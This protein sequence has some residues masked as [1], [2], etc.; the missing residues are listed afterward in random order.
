MT[1][2]P[3][4]KQSQQQVRQ[5]PEAG[6]PE[7]PGASAASASS[8]ACKTQRRSIH[9]W[10]TK[11][12][13]V[14]LRRAE[15]VRVHA[16]LLGED[17][18]DNALRQRG[19]R[20]SSVNKT[21]VSHPRG[22]KKATA[23]QPAGV[24]VVRGQSPKAKG[25]LCRALPAQGAYRSACPAAH[26]TRPLFGWTFFFFSI[27]RRSLSVAGLPACLWFGLVCL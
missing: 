12:R 18:G 22:K 9:G 21:N 26:L 2:Q 15:D 10:N 13:C 25:R 17:E 1:L 5:N 8:A 11:L 27:K 23:F 24:G 3:Q 4:I 20:A 16:V 14:C 7:N 19:L 6:R